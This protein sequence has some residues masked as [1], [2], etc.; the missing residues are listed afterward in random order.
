MSHCRWSTDDFQCD[1]YVY[2]SAEG[3]VISVASNRVVYEEPL[4]EPVPMR[5]DNVGDWMARGLRVSEIMS[6]SRKEPLGLP[7]DGQTFVEDDPGQ[8]ADRLQQLADAG[9]RVPAS[10][11]ADLRAEQAERDR[12]DEAMSELA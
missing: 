9:Y 11:I 1:V 4:P 7:Y 5:A 2:E 3:F 8:C 10:V 12:G 6:R